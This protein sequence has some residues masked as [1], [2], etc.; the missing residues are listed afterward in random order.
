MANFRKRFGVIAFVA[1]VGIMSVSCAT[2]NLPML[3][4]Y[5]GS[6]TISVN[7]LRG[8]ATSRVFLGF[9]GTEN[10]PPAYRVAREAGITNIS[11]IEF[12]VTPGI[13]W[14][15]ADYTTIVTGN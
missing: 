3:N 9:I 10:F 7:S 14:I 5:G 11:T 2:M 1:L 6:D 12:F 13:L 15:W 8:E 4:H